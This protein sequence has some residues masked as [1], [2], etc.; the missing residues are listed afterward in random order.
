M[1]HLARAEFCRIYLEEHAPLVL[2][3]CPRLR[4][5]AVNLVERTPDEADF[6]V[7]AE[8]W[9]DDVVDF[10]DRSRFYASAAGRQLVSDHA[11]G[12]VR[13]AIGYHVNETV[14]RDY[15]RDWP[16]GERSPGVKMIAP[17]QRVNGL[18]HEEFARRWV[19]THAA[20][21]LT[22]VPGIWRYVTNVVVRPLAR[23]APSVDG[24]VEVHRR[25]ADDLKLRPSPD[26]QA[27]LD[28]D[29]DAL[30]VRPQRNHLAEY[31]LKS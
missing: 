1:P 2:E 5:Y 30:I 27:I 26:G 19:D 21:A 6:D 11:A 17:L 7:V 14:Q 8:F 12:I 4:R 25:H 28:A 22:H 15:V 24:I 16:D 3:H 29:T 9:L 18:T 10:D 13:A 20:L 31:V 23:S